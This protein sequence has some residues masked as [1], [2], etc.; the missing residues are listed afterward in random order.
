MT[1]NSIPNQTVQPV[2]PNLQLG[3]VTP[4]NGTSD[5]SVLEDD[6][7]RFSNA[8]KS[9]SPEKLNN[10]AIDNYG[11]ATG[12]AA[13]SAADV[14]YRTSDEYNKLIKPIES[15][16]GLASPEGRVKFAETY[17]TVKDKP[18]GE[19]FMN[20]FVQTMSGNPKAYQELTGGNTRREIKYND[21]GE[22]IEYHIN[23]LG[24][25]SNAINLTTGQT[26]NKN[27][28]ALAQS[29]LINTIQRKN[30]IK[31][32]EYN[33]EALLKNNETSQAWAAF[34]PLEKKLNET[35]QDNLYILRNS[36]MSPEEYAFVAGMTSGQS[37]FSQSVTAGFNALK[38]LNESKN[39]HIDESQRKSLTAYASM[40]GLTLQGD[41][42]LTNSKGEKVG[43]DKLQQLQDSFQKN[44]NYETN[45]SQTQQNLAKSKL[46]ANMKPEHQQLLAE[47]LDIDK[48]LE[49]KRSELTQKYGTP[50]FLVIPNAMAI[51]DPLKRSELQAVQ[52]RFNA[53]VM[54]E[55]SEW[56]KS[57]LKLYPPDQVPNPH[58]LEIAFTQ[59]ARFKQLQ[60]V[61]SIESQE[62]RKREDSFVK[63][64]ISTPTEQV[65]NVTQ[66]TKP[67]VP[68]ERKEPVDKTER[69][70]H[71]EEGINPNT[72]KKARRK[73]YE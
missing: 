30:A 66:A 34:S 44:N 12:D 28:L 32:N 36:G 62:I 10:L 58:E 23:E 72:G 39:K 51:D 16:G 50:S 42:S 33:N 6:H 21:K 7:A 56:K 43:N 4:V 41:G 63:K 19:R 1:T 47:T 27:E 37:G 8:V 45:Y 64:A 5:P 52:G 54:Q 60:K 29:E 15:T 48:Q 26:V 53:D 59:S 11:T 20:Y 31:T 73:V 24:E 61:Y 35:K 3:S 69:K 57:Q 13:K 65:N 9:R 14:L 68:T 22:A 46:F 67:I 71:Y 25:P 2:P 40:F 55:F 17:Q 49:N 70:F 18:F 38:Q